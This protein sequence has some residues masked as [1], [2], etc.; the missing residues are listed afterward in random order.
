MK[1]KLVVKDVELEAG[2]ELE[3]IVSQSG[4]T[5]HIETEL[6]NIA[7]LSLK[8]GKLVLTRFIGVNE[9]GVATDGDND[10]RILEVN[11]DDLEAE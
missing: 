2:N 9:D 8:G 5:V 11:E 6:N 4:N 1:L 3:L 10:D 7:A